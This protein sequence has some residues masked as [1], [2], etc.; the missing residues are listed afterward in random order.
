MKKSKFLSVIAVGAL[1]LG[2]GLTSCAT[3]C[4]ECPDNPPIIETI[5]NYGVSV[6]TSLGGT[7]TP[8]VTTAKEGEEVTFTIVTETHHILNSIKVNGTEKIE[9][10]KDN[11]VVEKMVKDGLHI[12]A[13]FIEASY[14]VTVEATENGKIE[15]SIKGG[16]F[17][18]EVV[19]TVTA[20]PGF[21]LESFT[22]NGETKTTELVEG[23][24]KTTL[25]EKG[26]KASAKF[27]A[28]AKDELIKEFGEKTTKAVEIEKTGVVKTSTFEAVN[29]LGTTTT[30]FE[31]FTSQEEGEYGVV[32]ET[33]TNKT[34]TPTSK[35]V[36]KN[37]TKDKTLYTVKQTYQV[38][39]GAFEATPSSTTISTSQGDKPFIPANGSGYLGDNYF[40]GYSAKFGVT[41]LNKA[42]NLKFTFKG[43]ETTI[44]YGEYALN[45]FTNAATYTTFTGIFTFDGERITKAEF[46]QEKFFDDQFKREEDGT[47]TFI[48]DENGELPKGEINKKTLTL[49]YGEAGTEEAGKALP[50]YA[51]FVTKTITTETFESVTQPDWTVVETPISDL[52]KLVINHDYKIKLSGEKDKEFGEVKVE[53]SSFGGDNSV[54]HANYSSFDKA[55]VLSSTAPF[56]GSITIRGYHFVE[57]LYV[58]FGNA[59]LTQLE[60]GKT[61]YATGKLDHEATVLPSETV[62]LSV[63]ANDVGCDTTVAF[64]LSSSTPEALEGAK[65]TK[66]Q[67]GSGYEFVAGKNSG[68][69]EIVAISS[70]DSSVISNKFIVTIQE[71]SK[72]DINTDL[73]GTY[74]TSSDSVSSLKGDLVIKSITPSA[75]SGYEGKYTYDG[76][77]ADFYAFDD[78]RG[79]YQITFGGS[80]IPMTLS[81]TGNDTSYLYNVLGFNIASEKTADDFSVKLSASMIINTDEKAP[82]IDSLILQKATI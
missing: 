72:F 18:D 16:E 27:V 79:N 40:K 74:R 63:N 81:P 11:K 23:K 34:G 65:V 42:E 4:P 68:V 9:S 56:N 37:T 36:T 39:N 8:S 5:N 64:H 2:T 6:K 20:N 47:I 67:Y 51:D 14:P 54:V 59:K 45:S 10:I 62:E 66:S 7:I 80:G 15:S 53:V 13:T 77:E 28:L 57:T 60:L 32:T 50:K 41:N 43:S 12:E 48:K 52:T 71:G 46:E 31:K 73:L 19:L 76:K 35:N 29:I 38:K 17:G 30:K 3:T 25:S 1:L 24:Y 58:T 70:E 33:R 44:A 82:T 26:I 22:V 61:N 69:I 21:K 78:G 55:V 49:T 75:D